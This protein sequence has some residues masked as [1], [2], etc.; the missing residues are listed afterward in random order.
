MFSLPLILLL[1]LFIFILIFGSYIGTFG[2]V[3]ISCVNIIMA[4]TASVLFL[5]YSFVMRV[6]MLSWQ[7]INELTKSM[8]GKLQH[9]S[10]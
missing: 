10:A 4:F 8:F 2:S 6:D 7:N 1:L 9:I 3:F 5:N